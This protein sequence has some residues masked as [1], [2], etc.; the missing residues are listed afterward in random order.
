MR[1][2]LLT[3][4]TRSQW[5]LL[6][7]PILTLLALL[8]L[9]YVLGLFGSDDNAQ[10]AIRSVNKND[11][12]H[13]N[14]RLLELNGQPVLLKAVSFSNY[15]SA[16]IGNG[17]FSLLGSKHHAEADFKQ[18]RMLG[19][20][21]IRFAFNGNWHQAD[22]VA[23]WEWLDQNVFWA[24]KHDLKLV[25]DLH[26][27]IGGFWLAPNDPNID[28]SLWNDPTT[29]QQNTDLW[30]LIAKRYH[31]RPAI[32]AYEL[33][34]EPVTDD[35]TGNQWRVLAAD[36]VKA[37]REVDKNHL[38]VIS[39]L[40]GT[41]RKYTSRKADYQFLVDDN[42]VVYDFH[43]YLPIEY[44]HQNAP[45]V[46]R[47]LGDGGIY[48]DF[49]T[50]IPTGHQVWALSSK[51]SDPRLD[52]GDTDWADFQSDWTHINN[53]D[54][55]AGLPVI[56]M[57]GAVSGVGEFDN[58]RVYEYD[59]AT[60]RVTQLIDEP[61]ASVGIWQWWPWDSSEAETHK[62]E[63][64]RN[65]T[66][67]FNDRYSLVINRKSPRNSTSGWSS[68]D[69]WFKATP[70]RLYKVTGSMRGS[71]IT[72]AALDNE[73]FIGFELDFYKNPEDS[74]KQA[75]HFRDRSYLEDEFLKFYEFGARNDVPMSVLEFGTMA[76][77]V[78]E[79]K[80]GDRWVSDMLDIL[81]QHDTSFAFWN[82]HGGSMG[83]YLSDDDSPPD[84][85]NRRLLEV[86]RE[87]LK[88]RKEAAE[89]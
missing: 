60:N 65:E 51:A 24:E 2:S 8:G 86:L 10:R 64:L 32:A 41:N 69:H 53:P 7:S 89:G 13:A 75:F 39:S 84:Q 29:L 3:D 42:N 18:V 34:N 87:K 71:G 19:F 66:S 68:D 62:P 50:P 21:T 79:K 67:G 63:F 81:H 73:A 23:F 1:L 35:A 58:V 72:Y 17:G 30:R 36:L 46:D 70:G 45:W 11:F 37:V 31:D 6:L 25:L 77:T 33:L 61:L 83:L 12:I 56:K 54:I 88:D 20:N 14:G 9:C 74:S 52:T 40:Y 26:V 16:R 76:A 49:R 80:G 5:L 22:P 44:T 28:Y 15:Y 27:P 55:V 48:P 85:P 38:L 47:P 78:T 43:F 82:Y 4:S 57:H 59:P